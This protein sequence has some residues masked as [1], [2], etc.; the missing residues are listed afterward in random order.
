MG[1]TVRRTRRQAA[2]DYL[3][4]GGFHSQEGGN[5]RSFNGRVLRQRQ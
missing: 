2:I 5:Y 4:V 3:A 1:E